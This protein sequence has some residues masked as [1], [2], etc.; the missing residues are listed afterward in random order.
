MTPP[1]DADTPRTGPVP[2]VENAVEASGET[3]GEAKWA[4]LRELERR[5]PGL[6]K[7]R[8]RFTVLSEGERG[9]LGVG[10]TPA[11]VLA[12]LP[13]A[14]AAAPSPA[15]P[16]EEPGS[17]AARLREFLELVTA[18]LAVRVSI[19][20]HEREGGLVARLSGP[21]VGLVIGKRGQTIDAIQYLA[22]A[23]LWEEGEDRRDVVV[24]A[25]G[26]R[27]RRQSSLER[28]ADRAA[29]DA[30]ETG[31]PVALEPMSSTERKVIHLYLEARGG[32]TTTSQ[33]NEPNRHVVV[34]PE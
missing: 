13:G 22:N 7:G 4:A 24:D 16:S 23:I 26:Y 8:V 17:P 20:L 28:I 18:G 15:A 3:V 9:L 5:F 1:A 25:A 30:L 32:V 33:G 10:Y 34:A 29:R 2:E 6:D 21:D 31:A 12:D 14:T 19:G 11:R 27:R